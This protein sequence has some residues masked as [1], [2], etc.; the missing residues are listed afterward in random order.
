[1]RDLDFSGK[2]A[3]V[4]GGSSGIGN[5]IAQ[6]FR[7]RGADVHVWGTRAVAADY[8]DEPGSN[9]DGLS[10][11]SVNVADADALDA[12]AVP[13]DRLDILVL[14]QG[15]VRYNRREFERPGWGEVM[16][17]NLNSV[18]FAAQK[19]RRMLAASNGTLIIV[20]SVTAFIA[21]QGNPAYAAS[22]A[23]AVSLTKTLGEAWASEGIRVNGIAPGFVDTKLTKVTTENEK[24]LN[25]T[26]AAI[27][28]RRLGTPDDIAGAAMFLASPLASYVCG[29]TLIVDGG[30]TLS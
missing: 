21:A 24:R 9:L 8:A 26:L 10:Y 6:S 19:F 11:A 22:K 25:A 1:M 18:M 15:I 23:A 20:S 3:L 27:P 13:F 14:C 5:G 30:L 17:V 2:L 16:D 29:Q 7:A 4:V 28:Q 12:C